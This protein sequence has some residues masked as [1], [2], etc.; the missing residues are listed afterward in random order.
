MLK[1]LLL[2]CLMLFSTPLFA[3]ATPSLTLG[4]ATISASTVSFPLTL[5][6]SSG[7]S[8]SGITADIVFNSDEL[9]LIM[10]GINPVSAVAGEATTAA[11]KQLSQSSV[12]DGVLHLVIIDLAGK[13]PI[14]DGVL[15]QISFS[16]KTGATGNYTFTS[17]PS[18]TDSQGN[19]VAI[20]GGNTTVSSP[21]GDVNGDGKI[22]IFDALLTLQYG[23][24]LIQ[25]DSATDA[26]YL[27]NA[28]VAPL[29]TT[30]MKPG[31][32]N[33]IDIMDALV[34]LQRSVNL[35]SW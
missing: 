26:K 11:G 13:T 22:D 21:K 23:L 19:S 14:A 34:I 18:A 9:A 28:D 4:S 10:N 1:K 25:H 6:G 17:V 35:L 31:G 12:R 20:T 29:N 16:I 15:A 24:N 33:K 7:S 30:T 32:D 27:A 8:I 2:L 3:F 5:A